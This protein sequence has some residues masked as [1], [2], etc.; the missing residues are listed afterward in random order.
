[1][2]DVVMQNPQFPDLSQMFGPRSVMPTMIGMDRQ[3]QAMQ[4]GQQNMDLG[5]MLMQQK[6]AMNPLMLEQQRL[7]NQQ[8]QAQLPGIS[9]DS[10]LKQNKLDFDNATKQ[11][12]IQAKLSELATKMSEDELNQDEIKI[13]KAVT[14]GQ[15]DGKQAEKLLEKIYEIRKL[16]MSLEERRATSES[17]AR[18][19]QAG[20]LAKENAGIAAGKYDKAFKR[21]ALEQ[22][23]MEKDPVKAYT[24]LLLA[25]K[26]A[27][28]AGD[29][30]TAEDLYEEAMY[31]KSVADAK[32]QTNPK[33]GNV[34]IPGL[35]EGEIPVNPPNNPAPPRPAAASTPTGGARSVN[36]GVP[37]PKT[38]AEYD[39]LP[40]G[41]I[42]LDT[43]GKQKRKK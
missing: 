3:K 21:S 38:Q 13:K 17:V 43:D 12:A 19:N 41:T 16:K 1:M 10:G 34:N 28:A 8:M 35:T 20:A 33:P 26:R 37:A 36:P 2:A 4:M 22:A 7:Q 5:Q 29:N 25:S 31:I 11:Q 27:E 40:S 14:N 39:K 30:R 23:R 9:A 15:V 18:I 32:L 24:G 42:Y 6:Q